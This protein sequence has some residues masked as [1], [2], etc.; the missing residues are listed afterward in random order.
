MTAWYSGE[1]GTITARGR[2]VVTLRRPLLA[3]ALAA[4]VIALGASTAVAASPLGRASS[5]PAAVWGH[6]TN[7]TMMSGTSM[8]IMLGSSAPMMRCIRMGT[9]PNA[10]KLNIWL[11]P[12]AIPR[13]RIT[14]RHL[15]R[16]VCFSTYADVRPLFESLMMRS[17]R[18]GEKHEDCGN[19]PAA[20]LG[21]DETWHRESARY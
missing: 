3:G 19:R 21:K 7:T 4:G 13:R 6:G 1:M 12:T 15:V 2:K 10:S 16:T 9:M 11:A 14:R 8:G 18:L 20:P 17:R 5:A